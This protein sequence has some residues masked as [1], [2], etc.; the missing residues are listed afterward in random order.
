MPP[1]QITPCNQGS[2]VLFLPNEKSL[3]NALFNAFSICALGTVGFVYVFLFICFLL[4]HNCA[5]PYMY[6]C[7][8]LAPGF[9]SAVTGRVMTTTCDSVTK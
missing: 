3:R 6:C 4:L 5:A 9:V 8:D 2:L 7:L 1:I